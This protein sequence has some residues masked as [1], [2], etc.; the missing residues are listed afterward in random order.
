NAA[1]AGAVIE[2]ATLTFE[3]LQ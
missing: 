2:G 3:V 1:V